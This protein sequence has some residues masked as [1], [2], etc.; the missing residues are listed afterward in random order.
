MSRQY[1]CAGMEFGRHSICRAGMLPTTFLCR[2]VIWPTLYLQGW[3]VADT[4]FFMDGN[5]PTKLLKETD[6][7]TVKLKR[8][9]LKLRLQVNFNLC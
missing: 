6:V 7:S 2:N 3:N 1:F 8:L 9:L 4:F 5:L